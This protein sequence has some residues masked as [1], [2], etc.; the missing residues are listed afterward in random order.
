MKNKLHQFD[1]NQYPKASLAMKPSKIIPEHVGVFALRPIPA[2]AIIAHAS[3]FDES[4]LIPWDDFKRLDPVTQQRL[5]M[6]CWQ[7]KQGV[8][9]PKNINQLTIQWHLNH[10]CSPN[11]FI[12]EAWDYRTLRAIRK[13]EELSIDMGTIMTNPSYRLKCRCGL[14][15]CVGVIKPRNPDQ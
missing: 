15:N 4:V 5:R 3:D 8:H 1:I 6:F 7:S 11:V 10:S 13:G 9:A 14:P 12:D 2:N